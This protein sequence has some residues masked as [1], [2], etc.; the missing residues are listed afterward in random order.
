MEKLIQL[1]NEMDTVTQAEIKHFV[2]RKEAEYLK[3]SGQ[4]AKDLRII[5]ENAYCDAQ[6]Y[7]KLKARYS[8]NWTSKKKLAILEMMRKK[9]CA[10]EKTA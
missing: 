2:E 8:K 9:W 5:G 4:I 3:L 1:F 6:A 7:R 10:D